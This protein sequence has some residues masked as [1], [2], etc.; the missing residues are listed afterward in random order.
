MDTSYEPIHNECLLYDLAVQKL[1]RANTYDE[2][3]DAVDRIVYLANTDNP[4]NY[5]DN[6]RNIRYCRNAATE[7]IRDMKD[8]MNSKENHNKYTY[9]EQKVKEMKYQRA[10]NVGVSNVNINALLRGRNDGMQSSVKQHYNSRNTRAA[11]SAKL[12]DINPDMVFD[13]SYKQYYKITTPAGNRIGRITGFNMD[14]NVIIMG[15]KHIA[16]DD[17]TNIQPFDMNEHRDKLGKNSSSSL[18]SI[19]RSCMD[20]D[21]NKCFTEEY[22]KHEELHGLSYDIYKQA[23][24]SFGEIKN[25]NKADKRKL[26]FAIQTIADNYNNNKKPKVKQSLKELADEYDSFWLWFG[27]TRKRR[28]KKHRT[29]KRSPIGKG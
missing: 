21:F 10:K 18:S 23:L 5:R 15:D 8:S 29:R 2:W 20:G 9:L 13:F 6:E 22:K 28:L 27:G 26:I 3:K 7:K 17:V 19:I 4:L 24:D 1:E 16:F 11:A 14:K 25:I 12:Q